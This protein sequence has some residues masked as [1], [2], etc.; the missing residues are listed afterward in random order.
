MVDK[1]TVFG[2]IL[3]GGIAVLGFSILSGKYFS[4]DKPHRPHE[5]GYVIEGV[6]AS[7]GAAAGPA[8]ETLLASADVAAG[9][10]VFAKCAACHTIN[11][12]GANG[13]G[14]NLYAVMGEGIAQG[15]GGYAFSDALK[16]VGGSWEW[17]KMNDWLTSPRKFANG[18]KMTFAGLGKPEDRANLMA[19]LNAQGSNIA[20]PAAPAPDAAPAEGEA[21]PADGAAPVE[22]APAAEGVAPAAEGAATP[23]AATPAP[24]A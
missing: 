23:A 17:T 14:P 19:Y 24:A 18:T 3:A 8:I 4:A 10:K 22:G 15:R 9:E 11:Q 20:L 21:A 5:M 1:N 7:G 2:W 13:I 6:E 12:G 16:A